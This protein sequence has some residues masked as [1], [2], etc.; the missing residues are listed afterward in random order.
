M[1]TAEQQRSLLSGANEDEWPSLTLSQEGKVEVRA[2]G[3]FLFLFLVY[4]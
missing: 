1:N 3:F 2:T 4:G